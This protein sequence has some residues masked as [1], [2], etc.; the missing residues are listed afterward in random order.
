MALPFPVLQSLRDF[1]VLRALG[2][3]SL[4]KR[5]DPRTPDLISALTAIQ[6]EEGRI[7]AEALRELSDR[8]RVPLYH[9]YG[10]VT[11]YPHLRAEPLPGVEIA[12]CTDLVCHLREAEALLSGTA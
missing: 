3:L 12:V 7:S 5:D 11:F 9:L 4:M 6:E 1:C 8:E 2:G 10:L